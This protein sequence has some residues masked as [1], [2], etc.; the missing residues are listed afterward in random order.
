MTRAE[1]HAL[2]WSRSMTESARE[3]GVRHQHVAQACDAYDI[4]RPRAGH[5]QRLEHGKAVE[6][7]TLDNKNYPPEESINIIDP[8]VARAGR[9]AKDDDDGTA[10]RRA[11]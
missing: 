3:Y 11:A 4:A 7:V 2:A 8:A 6:T 10:R 5:W 9:S 1:L